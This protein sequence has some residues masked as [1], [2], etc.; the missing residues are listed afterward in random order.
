MRTLT[1]QHLTILGMCLVSI[2][3]LGANLETWSEALSPG[4][5]FPALGAIGSTLAGIYSPK[6]VHQGARNLH[7]KE[8]L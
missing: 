6:P 3:A 8:P 1:G 5:I 2:A 4:F 7:Q